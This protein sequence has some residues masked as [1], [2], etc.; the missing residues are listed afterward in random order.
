MDENV[1]LAM[2][3]KELLS[4]RKELTIVEHALIPVEKLSDKELAKHKKALTAALKDSVPF[5]S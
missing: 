3:Y 4:L 5:R 2:I 1:T